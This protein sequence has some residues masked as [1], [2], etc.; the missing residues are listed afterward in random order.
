MIPF[1]S[2]A[3]K[4]SGRNWAAAAPTRTTKSPEIHEEETIEYFRMFYADTV[5]GGSAC[6]AALRAGFLRRRPCG[7]RERLPV[8]SGGRADVSFARNPFGRG[9]QTLQSDKRKIYFGNAMKLLKMPVKA[10]ASRRK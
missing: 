9:P 7:I 10:P 2:G 1:F 4:R 8:R 3:R 6:G 5:L